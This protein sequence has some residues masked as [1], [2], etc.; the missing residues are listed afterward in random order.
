[1]SSLLENPLQAVLYLKELTA[2]VQNQQSLIQTQRYRIDILERRLEDLAVE[3]RQLRDTGSLHRHPP[4]YHPPPPPRTSS[5]PR[6]SKAETPPVQNQHQ[7]H[8]PLDMQLVPAGPIQDSADEDADSC[9][10]GAQRDSCCRSLVPHSTA[11]LGRAVGLPRASE[12]QTVLHQFCCPAPEALDSIICSS[13]VPAVGEQEEREDER[14]DKELDEAPCSHPPKY[15]LSSDAKLKQIEELE[16]K[17]GGALVSRRAACKIQTAFRQYQL[18]QNFQ[19]IRRSVLER[20]IPRRMSMR[21]GRGFSA[22]RA[23]MEGCSLMGIPLTHSSSMPAGSTGT[24]THLED[25]FSEQVQ[26]LARSI[27]EALSSWSSVHDDDLDN[28]PETHQGSISAPEGLLTDASAHQD[29]SQSESIPRSASK[30]MMAFRDVTVQ[31]D[32]HNFRLSSSMLESVSL[33]N[34]I[35]KETLLEAQNSGQSV[36]STSVE[37]EFPAPPPSVEEK[38]NQQSTGSES[39]G[40]GLEGKATNQNAADHVESSSEM[41]SSSSTS[42]SACDTMILSLPRT[43]CQNTPCGTLSTDIARKRLYRI[44][45]NLFNVLPPQALSNETPIAKAEPTFLYSL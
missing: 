8:S 10:D 5:L 11:S 17:Y 1:M 29:A 44:G 19:K 27:D 12:S 23:L 26:S 42:T 15:E 7:Q 45:L 13:S 41:V 30:L 21:R 9:S 28:P 40:V 3:N 35:S 37:P 24:L 38:E 32:N 43:H 36:L 20:G 39:A 2:I 25:T 33:G 18:S 14:Q 31:I 22:E 16:Q 6:A 4:R 34:G